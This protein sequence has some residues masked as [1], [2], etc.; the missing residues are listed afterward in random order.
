MTGELGAV[1]ESHGL[2]PLWREG[3]QSSRQGLGDGFGGLAGTPEGDEQPRVSF[4]ERQDGGAAIA[5]EHQVSLP[6]SGSAAV[7][8][9]GRAFGQR[10]A[11]LDKGDGTA[12]LAPAPAAF[13]LGPGGG[14]DAR[15]SPSCGPVASK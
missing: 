15:R 7:F 13:G 1:V 2:A 10:P 6:M 11:L 12:A 14:N 4:V 8:G 9:V 5:E 3:A